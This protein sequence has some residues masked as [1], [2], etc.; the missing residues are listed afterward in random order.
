MT[1]W[2]GMLTALLKSP[3]YLGIVLQN[4]QFQNVKYSIFGR[5]ASKCICLKQCYKQQ[6]C[7]A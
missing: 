6:K 7:I 1:K 2:Q 4:A 5:L 3:N